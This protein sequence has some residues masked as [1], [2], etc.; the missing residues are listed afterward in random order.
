MSPQDNER[1]WHRPRSKSSS[2]RSKATAYLL[3]MKNAI[4][5]SAVL[6][7]T[8]SFPAMAASGPPHPLAMLV[9]VEGLGRGPTG[10]VM[11]LVIQIAPEDVQRAGERIRI[12]TSLTSGTVLVDR[13]SAVVALEIDGSVMV[14][15]DWPLGEHDLKVAVA[16]VDG[17]S[18]GG[19]SGSVTVPEMTQPFES[20][21]KAS[22]EAIALGVTPPAEGAV[23][24][25]NPPDKGGIGALQ[26]E[27]E[28]PDGTASVEFLRDGIVEIRRNRA[29]WTYSVVLGEVIRRTQVRAIARDKEGRYLGEDALV[30]N[31]PTG[32]IGVE[33]LLGPDDSVKEGRRP[34]TVAVTGGTGRI[35]QVTL[36]IDERMV[37]RWPKCPCVTMI[38][39]KELAEG[40]ILAAEAIDSNGTRGDSIIPLG[41]SGGSFS[42][43]VRVELVELPVTVLNEAGVPVTGLQPEAFEILEDGAPVTIEGFGTTAD[44]PLSLALAVD[45]SGSMTESF[46]AVRRAARGFALDLMEEGDEVVVVTFSWEA[47]VRLPWTETS[48]AIESKL[49]R[50]VPEGG[51]SLHDA[52]VRSLEQFRGRRGRQ[53]LVLLTDGE[54]TTSRTGW[55]LAKRYAHT[56]RVPIYPIGLGLGK[57]DYSARKALNRLA[58]ETGGEAF[59]PKDVGALGAVYD[60]IGLLLRSQYL[61]WYSSG[62]T[63]ADTEFREIS[64]TVP[65]QP[66]IT[67]RTIRGYYPGK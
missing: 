20:G 34:I 4:L 60:R 31:N 40:T 53:A 59:F 38:P 16:S 14:Y 13:Q 29:P 61:I 36:S 18:Y 37:A 63:K 43:S 3:N 62:S 41:G 66:G 51:T 32:K 46:G 19:W 64:V 50:I 8:I 58:E 7:L 10:T 44:L 9:E 21:E 65:A 27:V 24:F 15:R 12:V 26:L 1:S 47:K 30:L 28:A 22:V 23:R 11:G 52:V 48:S 39:A 2:N 57:F 56:M 42:G 49:D 55:E 6:I 33:I 5:L 54:D 67:L 25:K 45:T 35:Q 17:S